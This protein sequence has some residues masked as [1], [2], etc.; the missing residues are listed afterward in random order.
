MWT[1]YKAESL[2]EQLDM[3]YLHRTLSKPFMKETR[4]TFTPTLV[5]GAVL[6]VN[7]NSPEVR[8]R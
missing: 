3:S 7:E 6:H 1:G 8:F 4:A 2:I 5:L